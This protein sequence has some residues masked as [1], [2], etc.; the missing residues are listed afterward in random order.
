MFV[1]RSHPR[2]LL[3]V[4]FIANYSTIR[5]PSCRLLVFPSY[6][7]PLDPSYLTPLFPSYLTSSF[8][9]LS[10]PLFPQFIWPFV[11]PS[12]PLPCFPKFWPLFSQAAW[13]LVL[14]GYLM[15]KLSDFS[16]SHVSAGL[17]SCFNIFNLFFTATIWTF[18]SG[19]YQTSSCIS[20]Y[21]PKRC[22]RFIWILLQRSMQTY[23]QT[24]AI[25]AGRISRFPN[26]GNFWEIFVEDHW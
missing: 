24:L 10:D 16:R 14:P 2:V 9:K 1:K 7:T 21:C 4:L 12:Y 25:C 20:L 6:L 5:S 13:H 26:F 17:N 15:A 19:E 8:P 3:S 18:L 11:F 22:R 23:L